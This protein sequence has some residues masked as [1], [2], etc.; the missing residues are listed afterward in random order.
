[1]A[2]FAQLKVNTAYIAGELRGVRPDIVTS[3]EIIEPPWS[4]ERRDPRL[5]IRA[6][7]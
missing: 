6:S 1:M 3:F 5:A 4:V 7:R 2:A